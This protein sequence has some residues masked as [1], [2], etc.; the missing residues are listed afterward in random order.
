MVIDVLSLRPMNAVHCQVVANEQLSL[1]S[2]DHQ[3]M[4]TSVEELSKK[5]QTTVLHWGGGVFLRAGFVL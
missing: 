1:R 2:H 5:L 4:M 3:W